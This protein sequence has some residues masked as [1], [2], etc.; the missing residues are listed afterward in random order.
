MA[1]SAAAGPGRAVLGARLPK[2]DASVMAEA[3]ASAVGRRGEAEQQ[4]HEEGDA[5]REAEAGESAA[6]RRAESGKQAH[7][8]ATR[9]LAPLFLNFVRGQLLARFDRFGVPFEVVQTI[10]RFVGPRVT[11]MSVRNLPAFTSQRELTEQLDS[12]GF[13]G[14]YNLVY[15]P[16][17]FENNGHAASAIVN[18]TSPEAATVFS[19]AW[20][21]SR[22]FGATLRVSRASRQGLRANLSLTLRQR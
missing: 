20:H 19:A 11:T 6:G 1:A 2:A 15:V 21:R 22:R 14:Q 3:G 4:A 9:A 17:G 8:E 13:A 18:F 7:E 5:S 16:R 12:S 10:G